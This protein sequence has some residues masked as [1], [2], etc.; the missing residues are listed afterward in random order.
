[1]EHLGRDNFYEV[2]QFDMCTG[3]IILRRIYDE[4]MIFLDNYFSKVSANF[5][6]VSFQTFFSKFQMLNR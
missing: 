2:K 5:K 3:L 4:N 6:R 1:M